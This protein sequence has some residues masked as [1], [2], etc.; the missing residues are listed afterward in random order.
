MMVSRRYETL[1]GPVIHKVELRQQQPALPDRFNF[2]AGGGHRIRGLRGRGDYRYV[3]GY[4][5]LALYEQHLAPRTT[6]A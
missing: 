3:P 2:P 1:P 4:T 5:N 6:G